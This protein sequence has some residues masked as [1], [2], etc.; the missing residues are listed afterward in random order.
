M[1]EFPI[2]DSE[3]D[4]FLTQDILKVMKCYRHPE[5]DAKRK[6]YQ[7]KTPLCPECQLKLDHHYFCSEECHQR[8]RAKQ[9][10]TRKRRE[11]RKRAPKAQLRI[12]VLETKLDEITGE[13][14]NLEFKLKRLEE[15]HANRNRKIFISVGV[16]S[17]VLLLC[18]I[19]L[20]A[21]IWLRENNQGSTPVSPAD[22]GVVSQSDPGYPGTLLENVFLQA[23]TL[24][25]P[26]GELKLEDGRIDIYGVALGAKKVSLLLNGR[27]RLSLQLS[28]PEFVFRH[29]ELAEGINLV[30]ALSQDENGNQAYSIAQLIEYSERGPSRVA[31]TPGLDYTHGPRDF[32]GVSLTFDAGGQAGYAARMLEILREN[33]VKT[34]IFVTGQFIK[35]NPGL[36]RQMVEDGHEVGNHTYSHPH[37]TTWEQNSHHWTAPGVTKEF[38]Q[39]ELLN[40][41]HLFQETTGA[42]MAPFW[43]APYGEHNREIRRWAEEVGFYH[44][45]WSR[46]PGRNYDTLDW[47]VDK[48]NKYYRSP[49]DIRAMLTELSRANSGDGNDGKGAIVLMH[50]STE[51]GDKFP[52]QVL[53]P[54]LEAFSATGFKIAKISEL[55]PGIK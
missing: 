48:R 34:T 18:L 6:C 25:L 17:S 45:G 46:S 22:S 26:P 11:T 9:E 1:R 52:D 49:E 33:G 36:V 5:R 40:T 51:R 38:V 35:D 55:L 16:A 53:A 29:I 47:L 37:L 28:G 27:E 44:I 15:E 3:I 21:Y 14:H 13:H 12:Q 23:P 42:Q 50:L 32:P 20:S 24:E 39:A 10:E 41:A 2:P 7:C 4:C 43:R 8:W 54:A 31:Y 30:Q 19:G